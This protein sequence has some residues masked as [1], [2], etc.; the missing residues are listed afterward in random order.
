MSLNRRDFEIITYITTEKE[1]TLKE[2][3]NIFNTSERNIRYCIDNINFYLNGFFRK[4]EIKIINGFI[5]VEI[6]EESL[7]DFFILFSRNQYMF[8]K[9]EREEYISI[10][11]LFNENTYFDDLINYFQISNVTLTKDLK[12]IN[13]FLDKFQLYIIKI[14]GVLK[15]TGNEKKLR[16]LKMVFALKYLYLKDNKID[17][18]KQLF[19]FSRD[20]I[21]ILINYLNKQDINK[22][23]SIVK[24]IEEELNVQF[25]KEFKNILL[26]YLIATFERIS[27]KCIINKK[28]NANFLKNTKYY[29]IIQ[30]RVFENNQLYK[31][32]A[33]HLAEYFLSGLNSE[34]FYE[35]RFLIDNFVFKLLKILEEKKE[36]SLLKNKNLVEDIVEYLVTA[37]YRIKNNFT[38]KDK[39][40]LTNKEKEIFEIIKNNM[41]ILE[42][43]LNE[44]LRNE[45]ISNISKIVS[46]NIEK[47]KSLKIKL[48]VLSEIIMENSKECNID[49]ISRKL[50][51]IYPTLIEDDRDN[52]HVLSLL[53]ILSEKD[54]IFNNT[55]EIKDFI[56]PAI[57]VLYNNLIEEKYIQEIYEYILA[58]N[59]DYIKEK[60]T[61]ICY[62]KSTIGNEVGIVMTFSKNGIYFA[63]DVFVKNFVLIS[64]ID[65]FKHLK[66]I[67]DLEK[68]VEGNLT[69]EFIKIN[70]S[71]LILEKIDNFLNEKGKEINGL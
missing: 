32:E 63:D 8:S 38:L 68:I 71:N 45:E 11:L 62:S 28:N 36:I 9:E 64:N 48:S 27:K 18:I 35:N 26:I 65:K 22:C 58:K 20:I 54:I 52:L 46:E 70:Q 1:T 53:D 24:L 67:N 13:V 33:L 21:D 30:E 41:F 66:I 3:A 47:N 10:S 5:K 50:L 15:I 6:S 57:T 69:E 44:P 14:D 42:K 7:E 37:I 29:K 19:F 23:I 25:E 43:Y 12:N 40:I 16:H 55:V 51:T 4:Q 2:L 60:N 61:V 56:I 17:Y 49:N 39:V 31:Y 59:Y 34:N